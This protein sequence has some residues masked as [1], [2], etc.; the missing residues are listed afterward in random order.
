MSLTVL[1]VWVVCCLS[2][3]RKKVRSKAAWPAPK[4]STVF[5][6]LEVVLISLRFV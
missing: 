6:L 4:N 5:T 2:S 3:T 1:D